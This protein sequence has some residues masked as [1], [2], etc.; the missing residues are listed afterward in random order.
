LF[1]PYQYNIA[2]ITLN[3]RETQPLLIAQIEDLRPKTEGGAKSQSIREAKARGDRKT[4][5]IDLL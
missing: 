2:I 5:G 1:V 4:E 3:A